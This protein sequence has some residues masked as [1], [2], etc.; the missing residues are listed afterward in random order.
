MW[1]KRKFGARQAPVEQLGALESE[2]M[3]RIWARGETSVRDLHDEIASRLAYTTVMTTLDRLFKKGLLDRRAV[4]RAFH[5]TAR[6]S[7]H[8]YDQQLTQHLLGI[9]VE[10]SG[11]KQALLSCFVDYVS[12]SDRKLLD[13]LDELIKAKKR[14]LRAS[15]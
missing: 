9:A 6:V 4:G 12:D 2:L 15:R 3:E 7:K 10:E 14:S 13:E 8:D 1:L 11:S 5:Y